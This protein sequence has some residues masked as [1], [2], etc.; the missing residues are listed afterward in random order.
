MTNQLDTE[1][2]SLVSATNDDDVLQLLTFM[3][4]DEIYGADITQVQEVLEYRRITPVPRTPS[5]MLGVINLR[6]KVV[7]VLDLRQQFGM[8]VSELTVNTCIVIIDIELENE[9]VS[10]GLLTDAV[11]EV[12]EL[13]HD[14]I[15]PAPRIGSRIDTRFISGMGHHN[16]EFIIILNLARVLADE[17]L[18]DVFES[19]TNVTDQNNS[20]TKDATADH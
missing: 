8:A 7:P 16:E 1:K 13:T 17:E 10:L 20:A 14:D 12:I 9:K 15:S 19:I 18:G 11:K 2:Q 6:G 3:L 5:F 4:D